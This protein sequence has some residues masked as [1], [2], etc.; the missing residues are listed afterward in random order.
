MKRLVIVACAWMIAGCAVTKEDFAKWA[1]QHDAALVSAVQHVDNAD[2]A[3]ST[4]PNPPEQVPQARK[5]LAEAKKDIGVAQDVS[6]KVVDAAVVTAEKNEKLND[7]IVGPRGKAIAAAI[8]VIIALLGAAIALI[9][10]G[11]FGGKLASIPFL[12][13]ALIA[14][15]VLPNTK[16][17]KV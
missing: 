8:G 14:I 17:K 3:L 16:A 13:A 2:T 7:A 1:K 6:K 9:R 15:K 11:G 4:I 5:E 12:G 10:F